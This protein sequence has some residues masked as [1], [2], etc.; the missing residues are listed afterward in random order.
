VIDSDRPLVS[1]LTLCELLRKSVRLAQTPVIILTQIDASQNRYHKAVAAGAQ[2]SVNSA[3][4]P[5]EVAAQILRYLVR[6]Q[7]LLPVTESQRMERLRSYRVLDTPPEAV[8]DDLVRV[9]SIV[10]ETPIALI[11][12]VDTHRQWFKARV[13]LGATETP[14]EDAFCAHAIHHPELMEVPDA[15]KDI[16]FADNPL[17][18]G[19]PDIRFYAGAPLTAADGTAAGTLC[20]IDRKQRQLRPS[21]REALTALGRV[22]VYLLEQRVAR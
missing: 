13:G 5:D 7:P 9:A 11:S 12:L 22:A 21:Q 4:S 16:R 1:A 20:V 17:V 10:C 2:G 14:R 15:T 6:R 19:A 3:Q 18:L 8:F